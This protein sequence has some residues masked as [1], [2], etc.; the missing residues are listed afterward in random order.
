MITFY[1]QKIGKKNR[2]KLVIASYYSQISQDI[3]IEN[4]MDKT[5]FDS[6][7]MPKARANKTGINVIIVHFYIRRKLDVIRCYT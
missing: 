1:R 6:P 7:E 3:K 2:I 5:S 4:Y